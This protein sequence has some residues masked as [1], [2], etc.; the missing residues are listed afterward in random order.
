M[1]FDMLSN[2]ELTAWADTY[3][4]VINS[5][6]VRQSLCSRND[7]LGYVSISEMSA[8]FPVWEADR[9]ERGTI[10]LKY[11]DGVSGHYMSYFTEPLTARRSRFVIF[12]PSGGSDAYPPEEWWTVGLNAAFGRNYRYFVVA[13]PLQLFNTFLQESDDAWCQ[14]WS[15]AML[16]PYLQQRVLAWCDQRDVDLYTRRM[17]AREIVRAFAVQLTQSHFQDADYGHRWTSHERFLD[18]FDWRNDHA[19]TKFYTTSSTPVPVRRHAA[20]AT[21]MNPRRLF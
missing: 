3:K 18:N 8:P 6:P 10:E 1:H 17:Q 5:V 19:W 15:L 12:D 13:T 9:G 14:T 16:H 2:N 20:R 4:Q 7:I 21:G 11:A